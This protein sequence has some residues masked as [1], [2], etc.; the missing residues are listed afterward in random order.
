MTTA[1]RVAMTKVS[2]SP[3]AI[4]GI[5]LTITLAVVLYAW[6]VVPIFE[7]TARVVGY[8]ENTDWTIIVPETSELCPGDVMRFT[9]HVDVLKAPAAMTIREGWCVADGVCPREYQNE[10]S[11]NARIPIEIVADGQRVVPINMEPGKYE[12]R[13]SNTAFTSDGISVTGYSIFIT[14]SE[15]CAP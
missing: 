2:R 7:R 11:S 12:Y 1:I 6:T 10:F 13:H 15:N 4:A 3:H 9:V 14:V 8:G 5:A